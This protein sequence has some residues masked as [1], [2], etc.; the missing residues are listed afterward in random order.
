MSEQLAHLS[1]VSCSPY[2]EAS[3]M[4]RSL[5]SSVKEGICSST[6]S[7]C[8]LS[9]CRNTKHDVPTLPDRSLLST[10][11]LTRTSYSWLDCYFW[12]D[13]SD[14]TVFFWCSKFYWQIW[15]KALK[16]T[17]NFLYTV[18]DWPCQNISRPNSIPK[19]AIKECVL[20]RVHWPYIICFS[21]TQ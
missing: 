8:F 3:S 16:P 17:E 1:V 19:E 21:C 12:E 10:L 4:D 14:G 13:I 15:S 18:T 11:Q 6:K 20:W 7:D 2:G 9:K 5:V